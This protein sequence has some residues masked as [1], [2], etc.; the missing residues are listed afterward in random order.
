M[1]VSRK[2]LGCNFMVGTSCSGISRD[3]GGGNVPYCNRTV[4]FFLS[5][6]WTGGQTDPRQWGHPRSPGSVA[7][8]GAI[9]IECMYDALLLRGTSELHLRVVAAPQRW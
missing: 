9:P 8:P 4:R 7:R 1:I 3:L 5:R 2:S 6:R